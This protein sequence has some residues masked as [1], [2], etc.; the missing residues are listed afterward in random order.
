[1]AIRLSQVAVARAMG[2]SRQRVQQ[3]EDAAIGKICSETGATRMQI[4]AELA[5]L[6]ESTP[7]VRLGAV[8]DLAAATGADPADCYLTIASGLTARV[9][10]GQWQ[11]GRER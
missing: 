7:L 8:Q 4:L 10:R 5:G 6:G 1:V 9:R 3:I 11:K 2:I